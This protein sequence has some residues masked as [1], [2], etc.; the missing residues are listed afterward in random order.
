MEETT[1][2]N[3]LLADKI[4]CGCSACAIICPH[5]AIHMDF[6]RDGAYRPI[7]DEE[8]CVN[9]HLCEKVCVMLPHDEEIFLPV[10]Q[11]EVYV[12]AA[13]D[14]SILQ[15]SS[16]G[17]IGFVLARKGLE[18]GMP[19]CG[20]TYDEEYECARHVVCR[21]D[22]ELCRTQ[23]SKYLQSANEQAFREI[24]TQPKGVIFG[25]PCQI[26][27]ADAILRWKNK[28]DAFMLVDIFCHGVPNQLLWKGHLRYLKDR[29]KITDG[30]TVRFRTG[31]LFRICVGRYRAWYNEDAFYTFFLR[32][33]MKNLS[34]YNCKLRR[35][36]CAD[37]R[38]GDCMASKY[39][40][41]AFSP[42][43]ILVNTQ[44]GEDFLNLCRA[45]LEIYPEKYQVIDSIQEREN[46]LMPGNWEQNIRSL[47]N[48]ISPE[49]L[50]RDVMRKGRTKSF[51]KHKLLKPV[52]LRR[53]TD[54]LK[55]MAQRE[56]SKK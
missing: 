5:G 31:K 13:K 49:E 40:A 53:G 9:C 43:C 7:V 1:M 3:R 55:A 35:A 11:E 34:C 22:P 15:N 50:I 54:D 19:V 23:G 27:G 2:N 32:G 33:W 48:G 16:S 46:M 52:F 56:Q 38:I 24:L 4:C 44:R 51:I 36:S 41:L 37:I 39:A 20:V 47:Q 21:N 30:A 8:K 29:G 26:A 10:S 42:S 45:E 18:I 17:G 25:T 6:D 28:R 12:S 14:R